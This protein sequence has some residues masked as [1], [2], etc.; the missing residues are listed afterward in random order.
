MD[1]QITGDIAVVTGGANGLGRATA[2]AF[3]EEGA[4]VVLIDR[5]EKVHDVA[6]EVNAAAAYAVDVTETKSVAE[7]ADEIRRHFGRCD[8]VVHAA[9]IGSGRFGFPFWNLEPGDW[10][11]VLRVNLRR[12]Q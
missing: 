5:D 6:A 11:R 4:I 10:E 12:G 2:Q 8:H 9:G 7:T 3:A 1:L